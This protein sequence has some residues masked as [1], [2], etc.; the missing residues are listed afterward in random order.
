MTMTILEAIRDPQLFGPWF[1]DETIEG[2]PPPVEIKRSYDNW[3]VFL[4][5]LFA[6]PLST[7]Q[8]EIYRQCTQR[9][10]APAE[11][12]KE[13]WLICGRRGG[14]SFILATI[15]VYLACFHDYRKHLTPGE[16]GTIMVIASDKKQA[17]VIMGYIFGF[18]ETV[19]M[20]DTLVDKRLW[21][22]IH[23]TNSISIEVQTASFRRVRGYTVVAALCDEIAFWRSEDSSNPDFEI[24]DAIRPAMATIPNAML[25][26]ASSPYSRRGALWDAFE[27]MFGKDDAPALVWKAPTRTMNPSVRKRI[28]DEA[29]ERDPAHARA[30]YDAEFRTDVEAFLTREVVQSCI[31]PG[32]YERPAQR[33]KRYTAFVD[34]SGG[35][36][37]SFSLAIAHKEADT[38]I[39]DL[40]RDRKPPFSPEAVVEEFSDVMKGYRITKVHGDRYAGEW[41]REQFRKRGINYV[42]S[43]RTKSMLYVSL[44]P[45][46][47]SGAVDL[48]DNTRLITQLATLERKTSRGGRDTVDHSP[49]GFD[50][51]ANA[52]AGAVVFAGDKRERARSSPPGRIILGYANAK[53]HDRAFQPPRE[54]R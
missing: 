6:Q 47:N 33:S 39:L 46:I 18:L 21:E 3:A 31:E 13:A 34:P 49:G 27:R 52:V 53:K 29:R 42:P 4:S 24:L 35:S 10:E 15:A 12:C 23:L 36:H 22:A 54:Q 17:R 44:L 43:E 11:P 9:T 40:V 16:R 14:K 7:S 8:L 38:A 45:L 20:L 2:T 26:C 1:M 37:D 32:V 50:D 30:E 48:L 19:P 51:L 25:L 28:I 41:P 5:A